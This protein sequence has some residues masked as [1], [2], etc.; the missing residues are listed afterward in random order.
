MSEIVVE[1]MEQK[2]FV[3]GGDQEFQREEPTLFSMVIERPRPQCT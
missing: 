2:C 3:K 1:S